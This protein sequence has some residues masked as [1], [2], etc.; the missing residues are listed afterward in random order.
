MKKVLIVL[1][2][3]FAVVFV[4]GLARADIGPKPSMSF[5][6]VS[7]KTFSIDSGEQIECRDSSCKDGKPLKQQGPQHFSCTKESCSSLAYGYAPY[8]KLTL[9]IDGKKMESNVFATKDSGST[10]TVYLS[11]DKLSVDATPENKTLLFKNLLSETAVALAVTLTIELILLLL[12]VAIFK[13]PWKILA[14]FLIANITSVPVLWF[15]AGWFNLTS[16]PFVIVGEIIIVFYEAL[17]YWLFLKDKYSYGKM[18]A[19]SFA[20]NLFSFIATIFI[21]I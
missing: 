6:F 20:L 16:L 5:K 14:P 2:M 21:G 15:L 4:P 18:L 17:I 3:I 19:L 8:H 12:A 7:D 9:D 11:G 1:S 13:L 10:Y